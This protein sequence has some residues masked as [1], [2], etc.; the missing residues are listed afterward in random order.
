M[1]A[2]TESNLHTPLNYHKGSGQYQ[3]GEFGMKSD[4]MADSL[5][6]HDEDRVVMM[7]EM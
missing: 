7:E 2:T 5:L 1:A 4:M 3:T 6:E